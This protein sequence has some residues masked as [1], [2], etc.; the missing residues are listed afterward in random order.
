M[1]PG[2][3]NALDFLQGMLEDGKGY[4]AINSARSALS[5]VIVSE[6]EKKFGELPVVC[7]FMKGVYNIRPPEPRYSGVWDP[8]KVLEFLKTWSPA[9]KLCLKLLTIKTVMLVLLT[10]GQRGQIINAMDVENMNIENSKMQFFIKNQDLKQGRIG[11]KMQPVELKAYPADKRICVYNYMTVYLKRTLEIR[12]VVKKVFLTTVKPHKAVSRDTVSRWVRTVL[13]RAGIDTRVF[14]PGSTR[15]ASTS[16]AVQQGARIDEVL[17][18]A[19]WSNETTFSKWYKKPVK[20]ES[21]F[22][23][24]VLK[25]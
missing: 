20:R 10:T 3:A 11:Y 22:A 21:Q 23:Q 19:G 18:A 4:S 14:G 25:K 13:K 2:V 5:A 7:Q 12:G 8:Q 9:R 1:Q 17:A 24:K 6:S 16:K 15:A